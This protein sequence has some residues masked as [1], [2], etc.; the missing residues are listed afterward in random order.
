M[1]NIIRMLKACVIVFLTEGKRLLKVKYGELHSK[2]CYMLRGFSGNLIFTTI[3][4]M[5]HRIILISHTSL[6]TIAA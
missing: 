1:S 3:A 5:L 4:R 6:L 2:Q